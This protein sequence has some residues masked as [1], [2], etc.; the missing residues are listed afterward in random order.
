MSEKRKVK[1]A[2]KLCLISWSLRMHIWEKPI[3]NHQRPKNNS[4]LR[5]FREILIWFFWRKSYVT[6]TKILHWGRSNSVNVRRAWAKV[7]RRRVFFMSL[8]H[9]KI[10]TFV[11]FLYKNIPLAP[12]KGGLNWFFLAKNVI[13]NFT[14]FVKI[15]LWTVIIKNSQFKK[16]HFLLHLLL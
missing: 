3:A 16:L 1:N 4:Q 10:T 2:A 14:F 6:C 15:F 11:T 8:I 12:F 9:Q 7:L 13:L 5:V